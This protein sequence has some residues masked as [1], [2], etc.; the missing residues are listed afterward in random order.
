MIMVPMHSAKSRRVLGKTPIRTLFW[1]D[2]LGIGTLVNLLASFAS[3]IVLTQQG[4][5]AVALGVH[6]LPLPL[7]IYLS[8]AVLRSPQRTG[9]ITAISV[10]WFCAMLIL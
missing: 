8:L 3:L 9:A 6:F 5:P 7:N 2:M 1:R 4:S 10:A